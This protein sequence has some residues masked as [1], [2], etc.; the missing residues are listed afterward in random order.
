MYQSTLVYSALNS[1]SNPSTENYARWIAN[2]VDAGAN[3]PNFAPLLKTVDPTF[4]YGVYMLWESQITDTSRSHPDRFIRNMTKYCTDKLHVDPENAFYHYYDDTTVKLQNVGTPECN[5]QNLQIPGWGGGSAN[6]RQ[7]SRVQLC[8]WDARRYVMNAGDKTCYAPFLKHRYDELNAKGLYRGAWVDELERPP[9]SYFD[10]QARRGNPCPTGGCT[11][12]APPVKGKGMIAELGNKSY[13]ELQSSLDYFK[14]LQVLA[15]YMHE[16]L[17]PDWLTLGNISQ[18]ASLG[19]AKWME[20]VQGAYQENGY[21]N[22]GTYGNFVTAFWDYIDDL[23]DS[24]VFVA[25]SQNRAGVPTDHNFVPGNYRNGLERVNMWYL[26]G[27]WML[28]RKGLLA[29]E[30]AN[31]LN[32]GLAPGASGDF[33]KIYW[34]AIGYDIGQPIKSRDPVHCGNSTRRCMIAKGVDSNGKGY[35]L[36]RRDYSK[37]V[38]LIAVPTN[39]YDFSYDG[40]ISGAGTDIC[41]RD[42]FCRILYMDGSL[43]PPVHNQ[44]LN[45]AEAIVLVN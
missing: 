24:R 9:T 5:G 27:Y 6:N 30:P 39:G 36:W 42:R 41:E 17:G 45:N 1:W 44:V 34:D 40:V 10:L 16:Q 28:A 15:V 20:S 12:F 13:L 43:S 29:L 37:A 22:P 32:A 26:G 38:I 14:N 3:D 2:H 8:V 11:R 31:N 23:L 35:T 7:E 4:D 19:T 33:T 21:S 18:S 25:T